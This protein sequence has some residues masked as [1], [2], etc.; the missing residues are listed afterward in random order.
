[1]EGDSNMEEFV[2]RSAYS[3]GWKR[4]LREENEIYTKNPISFT[5]KPHKDPVGI[6]VQSLGS[7]SINNPVQ[8]PAEKNK[9]YEKN[10]A[11]IIN[12]IDQ[13]QNE[14]IL[15][16]ELLDN[17]QSNTEIFKEIP[18][19]NAFGSKFSRFFK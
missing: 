6:S 15:M 16:K 13:L 1:M 2:D 19:K 10:Y 18:H 14:I 12:K 9:E 11:E 4:M 5:E 7:K 17:I 8:V 3:S